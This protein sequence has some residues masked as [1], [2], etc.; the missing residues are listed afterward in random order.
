[1]YRGRIERWLDRGNGS[2]ALREEG[3]KSVVEKALRHFD[4]VRYELGKFAIAGNHVHSTVWTLP[5]VDLSDVLQ[6]WK[7]FTAWRIDRLPGFKVR[8]PDLRGCLWQKES[9]DHIVR[10]QSD[11]DRIHRYIENHDRK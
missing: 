3:A 9:F 11:L 10:G 4:G 5:G 1:M 2:C 6:S 8:P 7:G